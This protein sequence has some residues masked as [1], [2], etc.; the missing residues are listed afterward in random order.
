MPSQLIRLRKLLRLHA[1]ALI[2]SGRRGDNR[3]V[4]RT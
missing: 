4:H 1:R 2:A 3:R